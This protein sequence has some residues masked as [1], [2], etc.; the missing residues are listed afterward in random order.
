MRPSAKNGSIVGE[1]GLRFSIALKLAL[2]FGL[3]VVLSAVN[4]W[5]GTNGIDTV[6]DTYE[7][8]ALRLAET[9]RLSEEVEKYTL[10]QANAFSSYMATGD[11]S[12]RADFEMG[13]QGLRRTAA[14]LRDMMRTDYARSL[15]D[16]VMERQEEYAAAAMPILNGTVAV[17]SAQ[18]NNAAAVMADTRAALQEAVDELSAYQRRRIEEERQ[19]AADVAGR[20]ETMMVIVGVLVVGLGITMSFTLTRSISGPVREVAEAAARLA[21]GDLTL[22]RLSV[23]ARDEIGDMAR[24]FNRMMENLRDVIRQIRE[25]GRTLVENGE[26][27]VAAANES[28]DATGQIA[29][30]VNEVSQG[31]GLQVQQ[32]QATR[33]AMA[34]LR[35]AIDQI[36]AGAQEQAQKAEQTSRSL[37]QMAQYIEQVTASARDV[38]DASGRGA[39][40]ARA[41]E[42]AVGRVVDGME[43]IRSAVTGVARRM[44]EL[45]EFSRQIGQIVD[46]ISDIADQ[47]NLLALNAAIEAARAGEHGRGFGV[48]A[49]EVRQLAE[50]AAES[51]REIGQLIGSI[52]SAIDAANSDMETGTSYVETGTELAGNAQA[53]LDEIIEA[54]HTT[55]ALARTISE[56]AAQMA[57]ASPQMLAAM[58]DMASVTEENTAATEEMAASSDQVMRA[59]DEVASISE[60]TAAGA[61][62][63]SASTEEISAAA[64]EMKRAMRQL[65]DMASDLDRLVGRFRL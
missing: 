23:A 31:T 6:V 59:V 21:D 12:H 37:E 61:E 56:A 48:V 50:R 2:T 40:R 10:V 14:T 39:E 27:L 11:P 34:Q 47:T 1:I 49:E 25:T 22:E 60:Q 33:D 58:A 63:V 55:D 41:G 64:E 29:A 9:A 62:E 13:L 8:G 17:G 45:G 30:A 15:I 32:V 7:E 65:M 57:E 3:M 16:T 5:V 44:D 46:M 51:T 18:F 28:S 52:Q 20:T 43:Q 36:A 38:A 42:E 19:T 26:K 35:A 53:A 4:A 24:A 54:I